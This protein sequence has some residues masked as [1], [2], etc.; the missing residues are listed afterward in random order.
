VLPQIY[1]TAMP[2]QWRNISLTGIGAHRPRL[3]FGGPLTEWT[4]CSQSPC[5]SISN[6][7]AWALLWSALNSTAVTKQPELPFG[8][9]LQIN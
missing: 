8:T 3:S 6:V 7:Y 9:D 5:S 4:A 1:N 2:W